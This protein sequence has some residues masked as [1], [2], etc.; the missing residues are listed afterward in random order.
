MT[1]YT[2]TIRAACPAWY[3]NKGKPWTIEVEAL[4][5]RDA[6]AIARRRTQFA[7]WGARYY[8]S[9]TEVK[10]PLTD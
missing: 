3:E 7:T 5:K 10:P 1:T 8:F 9:A 2:V 6:I 4:N